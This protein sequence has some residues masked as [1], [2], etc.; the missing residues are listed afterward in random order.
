MAASSLVFG[1]W[2]PY[3]DGVTTYENILADESGINTLS[4]VLANGS[5][6]FFRIVQ[7]DSNISFL[8][9]ADKS[10]EEPPGTGP[11]RACPLSWNPTASNTS[12]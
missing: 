3:N 9:V 8:E 11:W 5:E 7:K 2:L 12:R 4:G 1:N 10:F 6:N